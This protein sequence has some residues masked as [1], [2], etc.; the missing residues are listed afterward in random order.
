[1]TRIAL[2]AQTVYKDE[3]TLMLEL[4]RKSESSDSNSKMYIGMDYTRHKPHISLLDW[5]S[6]PFDCESLGGGEI[7]LVGFTA[8]SGPL[9][10]ICVQVVS[11]LD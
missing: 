7:C 1:M 8:G 2:D 10:D 5:E 11:S 3:I 6:L 9:P 4:K